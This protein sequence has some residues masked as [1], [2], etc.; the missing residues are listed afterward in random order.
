MSLIKSAPVLTGLKTHLTA[1]LPAR[2]KPEVDPEAAANGV[3]AITP[4]T[5]PTLQYVVMS[6]PDKARMLVQI[7][8]KDT[9]REKVRL[10]GDLIRDAIAGVDRRG[11]PTHPLLVP[12]FTFDVPTTTGD[13]RAMT[14]SGVHT[15]VETFALVWQHRGE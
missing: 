11:K 5:S 2:L 4:V 1:A 10:A 14:D 7:S 3:V 15:W 8:V 6:G 13:G 9:T 12:G